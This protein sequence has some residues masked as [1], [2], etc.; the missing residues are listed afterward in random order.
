MKAI[1]DRG[2]ID[3][4]VVEA[5][6]KGDE[7]QGAV[8]LPPGLINAVMLAQTKL[9]MAENDVIAYLSDSGQQVPG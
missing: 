3:T 1:V 7:P 5:Y 8:D 6:E 9:K 4:L 2:M